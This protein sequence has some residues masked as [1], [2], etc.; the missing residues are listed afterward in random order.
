MR[1]FSAWNGCS[2]AIP[3]FFDETRSESYTNAVRCFAVN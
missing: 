3:V 2:N 1:A